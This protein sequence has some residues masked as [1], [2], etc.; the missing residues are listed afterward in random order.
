MKITL[1]KDCEMYYLETCLTEDELNKL[2][3]RV[4]NLI[5]QPDL[6]IVKYMKSLE[7]TFDF[8]VDLLIPQIEAVINMALDKGESLPYIESFKED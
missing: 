1:R 2:G 5:K 3:S 6:D 7:G 8:D 4:L